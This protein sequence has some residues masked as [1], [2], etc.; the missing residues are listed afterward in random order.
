MSRKGGAVIAHVGVLGDRPGGIAQVVNQYLGWRIE[1]HQT[2]GILSTRGRRDW[3][4]P[5]LWVTAALRLL[6]VRMRFGRSAVLVHMSAKGSFVREG[7]LVVWSRW[8][9]HGVGIHLHGSQFPDFSRGYP[10]LVRAVCG[11]ADVIFVLTDETRRILQ[12]A[13]AT[14]STRIVQLSNVVD[15]PPAFGPKER[16]VLFGGEIGERKGAD[17]LL[18][19]WA[20]LGEGR[21]DWALVLAGPLHPGFARSDIE[22]PGVVSMGA[23]PH[24]ELLSLQSRAAIAVLPSRN[25]AMPMFLLESMA[26]GCAVVATPVGQIEELVGGVGTLVEV[27]NVDALAA[28]IQ[29]L[30]AQPTVLEESGTASRRRIEQNYSPDKVRELLEIEWSR[31]AGKVPGNG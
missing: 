13:L 9:G 31:L 3:A 20:Q 8:L 1:G 26:R 23:I 12:S 10:R 16:T 27:G 29:G 21:A 22:I 2:I 5:L 19:A 14:A 17:V 7:S 24:A 28:A 11:R 18:A 6:L 30:I 15:L 4:A 25:E